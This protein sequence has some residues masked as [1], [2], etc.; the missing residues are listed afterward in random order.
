M[1]GPNCQETQAK[2]SSMSRQM[3][4]L[5]TAETDKP[6]CFDVTQRRTET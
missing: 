2:Q 1:T 6:V 5:C 4:Q 3:P